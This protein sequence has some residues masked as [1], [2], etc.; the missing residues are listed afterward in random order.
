MLTSLDGN[1]PNLWR[2]VFAKDFSSLYVLDQH[3]DI[4]I[5]E[6]PLVG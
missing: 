1:E 4:L 3:N 6:F 5:P 2:A